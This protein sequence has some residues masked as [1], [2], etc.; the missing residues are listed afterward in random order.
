MTAAQQILS[1]LLW[2]C[3]CSCPLV[4]AE[5]SNDTYAQSVYVSEASNFKFGISLSNDTSSPDIYFALSGLK[6]NSWTAVGLGSE[7]MKNALILLIYSND[8]NTNITLSTRMSNQYK[9]PDYSSDIKVDVLYGTGIINEFPSY[10]IVNGVCRNCRIWPHGS[11]DIASTAAKFS[12]AIGPNVG[13]NSNN[14]GESLPYHQEYGSF[15]MNLIQ[16]T[17]A[18]SGIVPN[19]NNPTGSST[20]WQ[21]QDH[22]DLISMVHGILAIVCLFI[23]FPLAI[24][25]LRIFEIP[26]L[27]IA[28]Q[29]VSF[30]LFVVAIGIGI[31]LSTYYIKTRNMDTAHQIIG[32]I[33]FGLSLI[34]TVFG[35]ITSRQQKNT[36]ASGNAKERSTMLFTFISLALITIVLGCANGFL[37]FPLA[38]HAEK[39]KI[40]GGVLAAVLV[41]CT[42]TILLYRFF[43]RTSPAQNHVVQDNGVLQRMDTPDR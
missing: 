37:G 16:A 30:V 43:H 13:L 19:L 34:A 7:N 15:S 32:F 6:S 41:V 39:D 29:I 38:W 12:Y 1:F 42:T 18:G 8:N 28:V 31:Y 20:L 35:C 14:P 2:L 9:E 17:S 26:R 21:S 10:V 4:T 5:A 24:I 11:L 27:F 33:V 40:L 23:S 22:S 3:I 36:A 25:I